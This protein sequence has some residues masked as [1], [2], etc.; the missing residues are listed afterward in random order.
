MP[1]YAVHAPELSADDNAGWT[2]RLNELA[3]ECGC[4]MG[5]RFVAVYLAAAPFGVW[6]SIAGHHSIVV[7]LAAVLSGFVFA[8]GAGKAAGIAI[9]R[10]RL[11]RALKRLQRTIAAARRT[12]CLTA[13]VCE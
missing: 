7:I 3:D 9:A 13:T 8:A 1:R 6:K 12:P 4:A 10:I 5:A 11:T 2:A